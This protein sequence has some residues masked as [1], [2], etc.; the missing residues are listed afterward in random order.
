MSGKG[1]LCPTAHFQ[2]VSGFTN[3]KCEI[4]KY[5]KIWQII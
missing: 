4:Q 1:V 5:D 2:Y 3:N